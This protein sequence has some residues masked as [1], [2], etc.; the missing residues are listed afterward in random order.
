[1]PEITN[2]A[3]WLERWIHENEHRLTERFKVVRMND[4]SKWQDHGIA[5]DLE[6]KRAFG[7]VTAWAS[8]LGTSNGPFADLEA[9]DIGTE[10]QL[11]YWAREPL[12][13]MLLSKWLAAL[14]AH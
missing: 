3:E 8:H 6:G 2:V 12:S 10:Q 4:W 14:E 9:I 11:F 7:R 13:E 1:L 5:L